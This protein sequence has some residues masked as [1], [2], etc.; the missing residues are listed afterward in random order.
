MGLVAKA[1]RCSTQPRMCKFDPL[2]V[3]KVFNTFRLIA[4]VIFSYL[5]KF[6]LETFNIWYIELDNVFMDGVMVGLECKCFFLI[7][8]C[9]FVF[10]IHLELNHV[11]S[12]YH[13]EYIYFSVIL[14]Q[15]PFFK[16]APLISMLPVNSNQ[17][18]FYLRITE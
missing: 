16:T 8:L 1:S 3:T 4:K 13:L 12:I 9:I 14:C 17:S 15:S 2:T 5:V 18:L 7:E 10:C 11:L 6:R